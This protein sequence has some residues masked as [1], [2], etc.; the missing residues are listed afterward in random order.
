M[1]TYTAHAQLSA[2]HQARFDA[3]LA[4]AE[5]LMTEAGHDLFAETVAQFSGSPGQPHGDS[6][7][8]WLKDVKP[9]ARYT[10]DNPYHYPAA[11]NPVG[12][13]S[14]DLLNSLSYETVTYGSVFISRSFSQGV[15]YAKY[16]LAPQGTEYMIP[17]LVTQHM[18][19]WATLRM[20]NVIVQIQTCQRS[21]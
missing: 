15:D 21:L 6:R 16:L 9:F 17:R 13:L 20:R 19:E 8:L 1:A 11:P 7:R 5:S 4:K 2:A 3:V 10:F 18:L 12:V 14:G